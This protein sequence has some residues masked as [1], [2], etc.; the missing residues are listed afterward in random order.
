MFFSDT[1]EGTPEEKQWPAKCVFGGLAVRGGGR[2]STCMAFES[3]GRRKVALY[4]FLRK[5]KCSQMYA[6][7]R[8]LALG[9]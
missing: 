7:L 9:V 2:R 5:V 6:A 8:V 3:R 1:R 4:F